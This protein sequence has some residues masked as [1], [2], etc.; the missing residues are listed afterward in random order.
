MAWS[1]CDACCLWTQVQVAAEH[2][3]EEHAAGAL[4]QHH[5]GHASLHSTGPSQAPSSA[6]GS[7]RQLGGPSSM[8]QRGG[9]GSFRAKPDGGSKG[10]GDGGFDL[11]LLTGTRIR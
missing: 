3:S 1:H 5:H 4:V 9:G 11:P 2:A 6:F 7:R 10:G 8:Q